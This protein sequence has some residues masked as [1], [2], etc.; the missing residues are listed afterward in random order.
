MTSNSNALILGGKGAPR[1]QD[2]T[3]I[4]RGVGLTMAQFMHEGGK[5][6]TQVLNIGYDGPL[7]PKSYIQEFSSE[8]DVR[9]RAL[10]ELYKADRDKMTKEH[11][12]LLKHCRDLSKYALPE[13]VLPQSICRY[14]SLI[15]TPPNARSQR[16]SLP[17]RFLFLGSGIAYIT[18]R[19]PKR[20]HHQLLPISK[21]FGIDLLP[22]FHY[23]LPE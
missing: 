12:R 10:D 18:Q 15:D 6:V 23:L 5:V 20:D 21:I 19:P 13:Y 2:G 8:G 7:K 16:S 14:S 1:Y 17:S 22:R 9:E 4:R 3:L 11:K